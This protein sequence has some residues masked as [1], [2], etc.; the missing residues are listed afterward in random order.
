MGWLRFHLGH[1]LSKVAFKPI[2]K[3]A[4][5]LVFR[6]AALQRAIGVLEPTEEPF[7]P[8]PLLSFLVLGRIVDGHHGRLHPSIHKDV[9]PRRRLQSVLVFP[10]GTGEVSPTIGLAMFLGQGG[11]QA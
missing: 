7:Q 10:F 2:G 3:H 5:G 9:G 11:A 6:H 4:G 8:L 1:Q